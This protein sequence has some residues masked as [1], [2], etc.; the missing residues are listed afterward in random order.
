MENK[1]EKQRL[2]IEYL[3]SSPDTFALCKSIVKADY[4]D[5]EFRK[6][7]EF[8]HEYY[9]KYSTTPTPDQV[10]AETSVK[11]KTHQITKDQIAYCSDQIERF[12]RTKAIQQAIVDSAPLINKDEGKIEKLIRDAL[13]VSLTHDLGLNYFAN[14]LERLEEASKTPLRT[15]TGWKEI[16]DILNGGLARTEMLLFSANSGG[17]KSIALAN[18]AANFVLQKMNV[19]YITLEIS[20]DM[21]AQRFDSIFTGVD[22]AV[23]QQQTQYKQIAGKLDT[24][25]IRNECQRNSCISQRV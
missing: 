4:F 21:V 25:A 6:T 24:H 19:L 15:P 5:P 20:T 12:C 13:S 22:A 11:T 14:P 7:V 2:L 16:D 9:D 1:T 18:L 23:C 10:F 3:L 8:V 17:G